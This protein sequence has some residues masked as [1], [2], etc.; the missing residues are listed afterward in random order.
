MP[1]V[2]PAAPLRLLRAG[3]APEDWVAVFLKS[4]ATNETCQRVVAI[5]QI[6]NWR[7]LA[8]LR[9]RNAG[10]WNIYVS[11]NAVTANGRS[12]ARDRVSAVRHVFLEADQDGPQV[13]AQTGE[14]I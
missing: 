13:L 4:Y 12:R 1:L 5:K 3:Y 11:V 9:S 14:S 7:F 8:W 6:A 2:E 10:G